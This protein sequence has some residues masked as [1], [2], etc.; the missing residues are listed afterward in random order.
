MSFVVRQAIRN[1]L[2]GDDLKARL[3]RGGI[4]SAGIQATNRVLALA[5]GIVLARILGPDGYG[6]YA[7]AFAVMSLLMVVAEAGVPTLLMREVAA[8]LGREEWGLMRGALR[9]AGQF[10]ALAA[11]AVAL[12]GLLVLWVAADRLSA[13]MFYTMALML[14]VLPL[15]AGA[16]TVAQA[17]IGLH[18]VV[19]GQAVNM[20]LQPLLVVAF[21]GGAFLVWPALR[22]P[23]YAMAAQLFAVTI[24]LVVGLLIL[25]R[26]TPQETRT[27]PP[28]YR[29]REWLRS[30]LPFML[31]GGAGIIN[32]QT[33][34]IMLG[35]FT[36]PEEVGIYRVAVQ[37]A[38]LVAFSLQVVNAVVAPQFSRLFAQ[39]DMAR[40]QRL[41]T[42][43]ARL[44][45]LAALPVALV[46]IL[47][48]GVLVSWVFG[49]G[50]ASAHVPLA[51]LAVGQLVNAGFGS[52]G[53]LLNMTGYETVTA[54][55]L[56]QTALSNIALNA[57][58]IPLYGMN[59]AAIATAI[60]VA[61]WNLLLYREVKEKLNID[62]TAFGPKP[63]C[64][65]SQ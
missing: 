36:G 5:L 4:G 45:L 26:L 12:L 38:A 8:S 17:L 57:V 54:R 23:H 31:I 51:I 35:W 37:G 41:V 11:I 33:D 47:A 64:V 52:V 13:E 62:S 63:I 20:L 32:N 56:W 25:R 10:V 18:R 9:R 53:F 24:V 30:A 21:V 6:V 44:V 14:L 61:F 19:L 29:S 49:A 40:L 42:Q 15:S 28:V 22:Q 48:G 27:V 7:Y 50:F 65:R 59:G 2:S 16:K 55:I 3:I 60:S 34:I 1:V 46:F 43:S 58:F 39:G